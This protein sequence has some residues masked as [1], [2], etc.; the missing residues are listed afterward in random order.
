MKTKL[1]ILAIIIIVLGGGWFYYKNNPS[2]PSDWL[3]YSNEEYGFEFTFPPNYCRSV[4][5]YISHEKSESFPIGCQKTPDTP[6]FRIGIVRAPDLYTE[7]DE[8]RE[9]KGIYQEYQNTFYVYGYRVI[10]NKTS[11]FLDLFLEGETLEEAKKDTERIEI[12]D[13]IISTFKFTK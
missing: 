5:N 2:I 9:G 1:I 12:F 10:K 11:F 4:P 6:L 8:G 13:K 7:S 3:A